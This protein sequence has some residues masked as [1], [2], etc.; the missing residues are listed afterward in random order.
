MVIFTN[1]FQILK[2]VA[3]TIE[4]LK[5]FCSFISLEF[6]N[7]CFFD[8]IFYGILLIELQHSHSSIQLH[9]GPT[10]YSRRVLI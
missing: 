8:V 7:Y 4:E 6:P 10:I 1:E 3:M 2:S 9:I 5:A